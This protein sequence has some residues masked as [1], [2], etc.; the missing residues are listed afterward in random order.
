VS[1]RL[2]RVGPGGGPAMVPLAL[3]IAAEYREAYY[4][5]EPT[6]G[7]RKESDLTTWRIGFCSQASNDSELPSDL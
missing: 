6:G 4:G 7:G 3:E 1:A 5:R 2:A